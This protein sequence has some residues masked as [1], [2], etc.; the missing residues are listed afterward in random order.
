MKI[1]VFLE[2][3]PWA[4]IRTVVSEDQIASINWSLM[5]LFLARCFLCAADGGDIFVGNVNSYK[6]HMATHLRRWHLSP[7]EEFL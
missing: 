3:T 5:T 7:L 4:L 6:S 1:A 2:A